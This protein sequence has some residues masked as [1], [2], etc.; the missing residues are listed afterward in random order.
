MY[1]F[2][3]TVFIALSHKPFEFLHVYHHVL[4]LWVTWFGIYTYVACIPYNASLTVFLRNT[5]FQWM[6]VATNTFV[7]TLMY[8]YYFGSTF[9]YQPWWKKYITQIQM[10]QFWFNTLVLVAWVA[11]K[12]AAGIPCVAETR[13]VLLVIFANVTFFWLFLRFYR[14][15]Y[16]ARAAA[17]AANGKQKP[18]NL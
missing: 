9:G 7:H 18:K 15:T 11:I 14:R 17:T 13:S 6:G 4:T 10:V 3:D 5:T 16:A 2:L 12:H 8:F 1:E